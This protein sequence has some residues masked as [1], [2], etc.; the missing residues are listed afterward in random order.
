MRARLPTTSL[1]LL[2]VAGALITA[3]STANAKDVPSATSSEAATPEVTTATFGNWMV[4][5]VGTGPTQRCEGLHSLKNPQGQ[6]V[7]V[8]AVGHPGKGQPLRLSLRV[9]VSVTI[10]SPATLTIGSTDAIA[11]PFGIC[12]PQGCFAD[13]PL[14]TPAAV[15]RL[16]AV[17]TDTAVTA[18]WQDAMANKIELPVSFKG[19]S[20]VFDRLQE[21]EK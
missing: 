9:P 12:I 8:L 20:V 16:R 13:I 1:P 3:T 5:C 15:S 6:A 19:L 4:V 2:L 10:G 7:A 17:A 14:N 11:L 18:R 21:L